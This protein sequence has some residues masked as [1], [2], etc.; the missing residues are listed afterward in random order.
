MVVL[1]SPMRVA[2]GLRARDRLGAEQ[3]AGADAI[4]DHD[5]LAQPLAPASARRCARSCPSCCRA[6]TARSGGSAARP[7][8][9]FRRSV[10]RG[11][12]RREQH[13]A[14]EE[15]RETDH[16][17]V[18]RDS[19]HAV[20]RSSGP[21][22]SKSTCQPVRDRRSRDLLGLAQAFDQRGAQQERA[23]A[24]WGPR[25]CGAA[26]R[27]CACARPGPSRPAG[28]CCGWS[29]PACAAIATWRRWRS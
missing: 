1:A 18:S 28:A 29:A 24:A 25:R 19:A 2:V 22:A 26:R 6:G 8:S 15:Q 13:R 10:R 4:V 16:A 12:G 5:L 27:G 7:A 14:Q 11:A 23:R 17:A 9:G 20:V 3:A 21:M